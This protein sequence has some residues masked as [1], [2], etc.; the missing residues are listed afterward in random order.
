[1]VTLTIGLGPFHTDS[2]AEGHKTEPAAA[3][4]PAHF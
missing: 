2:D 4:D 1:M 3:A